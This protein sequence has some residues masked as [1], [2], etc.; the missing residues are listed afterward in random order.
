[1]GLACLLRGKRKCRFCEITACVRTDAELY[2]LG[3]VGTANL[4]ILQMKTLKPMAYLACPMPLGSM[5]ALDFHSRSLC[6]PSP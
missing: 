2:T 5:S 6:F 1:M 3:R 4:P